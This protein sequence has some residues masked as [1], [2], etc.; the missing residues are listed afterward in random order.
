MAAELIA[1]PPWWAETWTLGELLLAIQKIGRSKAARFI[2][3]A[4]D[5]GFGSITML[6]RLG[7]LTDRQRSLLVDAIS[8]K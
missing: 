5:G 3:M 4:N 2:A 6:S 1:D 7:R 8:P